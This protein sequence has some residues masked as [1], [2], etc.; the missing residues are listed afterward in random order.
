MLKMIS[1]CFG[2]MGNKQNFLEVTKVLSKEHADRLVTHMPT[3]QKG[4]YI[5]VSSG[6]VFWKG[7]KILEFWVVL[8]R[9]LL[10]CLATPG[11]ASVSTS[12]CPW[13]WSAE[14]MP[15]YWPVCEFDLTLRVLFLVAAFNV[16][17]TITAYHLP[18]DQCVAIAFRILV[19]SVRSS[20]PQL[21]CVTLCIG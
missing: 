17:I 2:A 4:N 7:V 14:M 9:N 21:C 3:L 8:R 5:I 1:K 12:V 18:L 16:L 6:L 19:P 20:F 11:S 15:A 13:L 10:M